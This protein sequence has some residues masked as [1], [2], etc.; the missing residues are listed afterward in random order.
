MSDLSKGILFA[1]IA[2]VSIAFMGVFAK[3]LGNNF[4]NF[5][6]LFFRFFISLIIFLPIILK[7]KTFSFKIKF[8]KLYFFRILFGFMAIAF[9]FLAILKIPL[10]NAILL[11]SSYPV[12]VPIVIFILTREKTNAKVMCGIVIS[13][14]GLA[15]IL[16]PGK[17]II[18][19]NSIIGLA[20]GVCAAVSYVFLRLVLYKDKSQA[21]NILFYFFLCCSLFSFPFMVASWHTPNFK[22]II[23]LMLLGL[24]GYGYQLFITKALKFASVKVVSPL[25]YVSVIVGGVADWVLWGTTLSP[26]SLFG[27]VLT[28][29]GAV[30]AILF[31]DKLLISK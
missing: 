24:F 31:R 16:R 20:A 1:V 10:V 29:A 7:D 15:L 6:L 8:P 11:E 30:T 14:I 27:A 17:D 13:F 25:I 2:S 22:E 3:L 26:L 19:I 9:Y 28:V 12:F 5:T 4:N 21:N 23:F 18:D